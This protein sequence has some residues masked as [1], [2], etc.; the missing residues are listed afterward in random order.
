[1]SSTLVLF[2]HLLGCFEPPPPPE[3]EKPPCTLSFDTLPGRTF[4]RQESKPEGNVEDLFARAQFRKEGDVLKMKYT[5]RAPTDMYDYTCKKGQG[6]ILCLS[7]KPDLKQWCQT[8]IAN[9]DSCSPAELADLTGVS[10]AD[11]QAAY[12]A[13]MPEV[14][15][16]S[17]EA[18]QKM[19]TA[20]SSPANQ[21]RGVMHI[22]MNLEECRITVRD[23]YQTMTEGQLRELENYVGSSR[24]TETS[25][26]LI[27]EHC[28]DV[29]NLVALETPET[30]PQPGQSRRE[31]KPG[32]TISVRYAG[33]N[34]TKAEEG[35]TY[36]MDQYA[37]FE[38]KQK[39]VEV[40]AG[41]DGMLAWGFDHAFDGE[42]SK[43]LHLSRKKTCGGK[44][45]LIDLSCTVV[46]IA[47]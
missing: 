21:L 20:F 27:F 26:E 28:P 3:P 45:E 14:K 37:G 42:G 41:A 6:E 1:M 22:K 5:P 7:D 31:F 33:P 47:P 17:P 2:G 32:E 35:C 34:V 15:K 18:M 29:L 12:D 19:K 23:T 16:L 25:R 13:L 36:S 30:K 8:L 10:V 24:F 44:E 43:V 40:A 38:P 11:A 46:K 39:G 4:V 9:K